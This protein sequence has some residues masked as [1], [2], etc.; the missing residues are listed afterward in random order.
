[1]SAEV[2][3]WID[4]DAVSVTLDC[5]WGATGRFGPRSIHDI[6][7]VPLQAGGRRRS[8]RHD[9]RE[10]ALPL[11]VSAASDS[12]LRTAVRTLIFR[13]DPARGDGTLRV[14][15]PGGD[16]REI[17]CR[18]VSGLE[19]DEDFGDVTGQEWQ[20]LTP[21]F[22]AVDP[23]WS[24]TSDTSASVTTGDAVTFFPFFPLVL[25]SS[26]V[27]GG[28]TI[29]NTG[30]VETWP[31]I[32]ITGPGTDPIVRNSTT[33]E[34]LGV[35]YTLGAGEVLT[36]DT[37]PGRKTVTLDD[38]TNLFPYL[39]AGSSLWPLE[40]GSNAVQ[41]EMSGSTGD[42]AVAISYRRRWLSV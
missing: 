6:E 30:D 3:T 33:G 8:V 41:I 12:A 35:D 7:S 31:V 17:A 18:V 37:R 4:P 26:E 25:S 42:S 34:M 20:R 1:M 11:W 10:F 24:D 32:T 19:V 28:V 22:S 13:L 14:T 29:N 5:E 2:I 36:I 15:A 21:V 27:F 38:G 23:Y 9:V 40:R 39:T 16:Q